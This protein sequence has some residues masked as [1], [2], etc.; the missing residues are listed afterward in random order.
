MGLPHLECL[1]S[2]LARK[3]LSASLWFP[4]GRKGEEKPK[5]AQAAATA[6][7]DRGTNQDQK[8]LAKDRRDS[9]VM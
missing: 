2:W 1:F 9:K 7:Q 3:A 8:E 4:P 6:T 5:Y